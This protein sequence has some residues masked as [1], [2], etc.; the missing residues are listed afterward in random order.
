MPVLDADA[1]VEEWA[2]T[3]DDRYLDPAFRARR[4]QVIG[5]GRR[6]YWLIEDQVFPRMVGRGCHILGT[7]TGY[8]T[9]PT[10]YTAAKAEDIDSM[11][12]R[13][14]DARIRQNEREGIDLQI[15]YPTLFLAYP[16]AS[17]RLLAAALCRS[18][19]SW[20]HEVCSQRPDKLKWVAVVS[21]DDVP[22]AVEEMRRCRHELDA[23]GVV[24][25][26]TAGDKQLDHP[27]LAPF[28]ATAADLDLAVAIHV[29]WSCP[30]LSH[31]Y[32]RLYDSMVIPF[33]LPTLMA[34]N[35]LLSGGVLD[36]YPN[37]RV[38]FFEL[39][40]Q[41][42]PF[43]I[44]RMDHFYNFCAERARTFLP[45]ARRRPSEYL[46]SGQVYI[47]CEV[48]DRLLPQ[49]LA[50]MGDDQILFA[51]DIPH[52]DR[53][54]NAA[55]ILQARQDLSTAAKRKILYDNAMRFYGLS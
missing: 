6:A 33:G 44:D 51:S 46:Q 32:E 8:G 13:D 3:F 1:H 35:A 48:D 10:E 36:Q 31:L 7:P 20:M 30:P 18:Y 41:W 39:G 19:N 54:P 17:D 53:E 26:G 4:P 52:G 25:L 38:G 42:V 16:L 28:W 40:S 21:L 50:L 12:L 43:L 22:S 55:G 24:I 27:S 49:V 45:A 9:L 23:V 2:E 37:L 47:T 34:F 5:A 29:G 11:E 14:I 15:I